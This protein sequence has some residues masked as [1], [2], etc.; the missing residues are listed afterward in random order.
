M[1]LYSHCRQAIQ[2]CIQ[3]FR[4][5]SCIL[6]NRED[7]S[8]VVAQQMQTIIDTTVAEGWEYQRMDTV[9]TTIVGTNG[10]FGMGA[11]PAIITSYSVL[12]F[13]RA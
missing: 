7:T 1:S 3:F 11:Q 2:I 12:V 8:A 13:K 6:I 5:H 4:G 10:C 9:E